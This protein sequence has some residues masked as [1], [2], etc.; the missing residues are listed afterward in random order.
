MKMRFTCAGDMLIQRR[1][2]AG[3]PGFEE[4]RAQICKGDARFFN[5][6]TTLHNGEHWGNQFFG[7]SFLRADPRVLDDAKNFGFNILNCAN[8]HSMDFDRPG[9]M[10]T[11]KHV[12]EAGFV[13][14]GTGANLD[15][16]SAPDYLDLPNGRVAM[17]GVSVVAKTPA[18]LAGQQSRRL[19]GRPGVNG[20]RK[21]EHLQ[22]TEEQMAV[23]QQIADQSKINAQVEIEKAEGYH[24]D[25]PTDIA[26][27]KDLYFKVGPETKHVTHPHPGDMK[28]VKKAIYEA[29]MASDYI[30]VSIHSH[31]LAGTSKE[32][33]ADFL[34]EFA[35]ECI[36]AGAHA[37]IGHGPHLLRPL[38]IYKGYPIFYSL[39]DFVLHNECIPYAAE[40]AYALQGLTS[41]ATMR[42]LFC[43]RTAGYTRGLVRDHRMVES[44]IPYFEME[45]GKLTYLELMPIELN[46]GEPTWRAGNPRFSNQHGIIER[47]AQMSKEFGTEITVDDR[48]FGIVKL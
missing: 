48:G 21:T 16:A 13:T 7:G 41:D 46:F 26:S 22:V 1:I 43:D 11:L 39:G 19:P 3:Y 29:Q 6:E 42:E 27:L 31:D 18:A 45:D 25:R 23:I 10:T 5:L 36:D 17:I 37:V 2:P 35:R 30:L 33:P 24:A 40:E 34:Q 14:A 8:N 32:Y 20:L 38:E 47:L 12:R 15:E 44:V 4:V 9:L 28:R